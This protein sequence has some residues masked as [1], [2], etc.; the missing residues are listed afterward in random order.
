MGKKKDTKKE[1]NGEDRR[2]GWGGESI[3]GGRLFGK[4]VLVFVTQSL[5]LVSEGR[6]A[7]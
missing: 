6:R 7:F 5:V 1:R 2:S 4:L 3:F